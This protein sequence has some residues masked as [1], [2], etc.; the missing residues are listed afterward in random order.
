MSDLYCCAQWRSGAGRLAMTDGARTV[1]SVALHLAAAFLLSLVVVAGLVGQDPTSVVGPGECLECH[2]AAHGVWEETTHQSVYQTFHRQD[3]TQA[4]LERMGERSARRAMCVDC[5]YTQRAQ[6]SRAARTITGVSCESCHGAA[7]DWLDIHNNYGVDAAGGRAT[8]E[9]ETAENRATRLQQSTEMGMIRPDQ[10]YLLVQNCFECHTVPREELVNTGEHAP[11]SDFDL[12]AR[13]AEIRHN[14]QLSNEQVNREAARDYDPAS[15][16]RLFG[17]LGHMVDLEYALRGLA[18]ATGAGTYAQAMTDRANG[19]M[20]RL[21]AIQSAA[22]QPAIEQ[23]LAAAGQVDLAPN[24][25]A[26]LVGAA[27]RIR[28]VAMAFAAEHD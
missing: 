28:T 23:V 4:I 2:E 11:G 25:N 26:E 18:E 12:V 14:F 27:D 1:R 21:R 9:T 8:R 3:E 24:A 13:L 5:H 10:P 6:G 16:N 17:V 19:A 20:E 22:P 15:R 7:A